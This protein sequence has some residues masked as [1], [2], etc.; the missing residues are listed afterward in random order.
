MCEIGIVEERTVINNIIQFEE[1]NRFY[2]EEYIQRIARISIEWWINPELNDCHAFS[3]VNEQTGRDE[4]FLKHIPRNRNDAFIVAHEMMHV[5]RRNEGESLQIG[6]TAYSTLA[7][8]LASML[9]DSIVDS[10]LKTAYNFDLI[11]HYLGVDMLSNIEAMRT[12]QYEPTDDIARLS[13]MFI[14]VSQL[15]CYDLIDN[16]EAV[17]QLRMYKE[18]YKLWHRIIA[19]SSENLYE[20]IKGMGL[21]T[22]EKREHLFNIIVNRYTI[23]GHNLSEFLYLR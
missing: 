10:Y 13:E 8:H 12:S 19:E 1:F 6:S 15:L 23:E 11:G 18:A 21:E 5:I 3:G 22:I 7:Q 17:Q 4:I 16:E 2:N 20:I 14:Y 9:E